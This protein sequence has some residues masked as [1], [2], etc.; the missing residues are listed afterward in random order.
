MEPASRRGEKHNAYASRDVVAFL[1]VTDVPAAS[2]AEPHPRTHRPAVFRAALLDCCSMAARTAA[3][4]LS[5]PAQHLRDQARFSRPAQCLTDQGR[6]TPGLRSDLDIDR[7]ALPARA[8]HRRERR[9]RASG[10]AAPGGRLRGS[11]GSR[12]AFASE[13]DSGALPL[14][15]QRRRGSKA[16]HPWRCSAWEIDREVLAVH[17]APRR[18]VATLSRLVRNA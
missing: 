12:S 4:R 13:I 9:R 10:R 8:Q 17:A 5:R 3:A 7:E 11:A 2:E 6:S 14:R 15:A 1:D 16:R 18:S